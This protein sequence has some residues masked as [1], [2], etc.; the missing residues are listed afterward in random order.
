MEVEHVHLTRPSMSISYVQTALVVH[1][2]WSVCVVHCRRYRRVCALC[3]A[4]ADSD[5]ICDDVDDCVGAYDE[6]NICNGT[7]IPQ[8]E[9]DCNG[10]VLD[11]IG[12]CGGDCTTD[13]DLDNICDDVDPGVGT[14]D[15][16]GVCNGDCTTDADSDGIC[17][18]VDMCRR[19]RR[20]RV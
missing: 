15:A 11:V 3:A 5:G 9:C 10:N 18:D 1:I 8:D 16:I 7:S 4:D 12:V 13:A 6:C 20:Y 17:D 2:H 14:Y 19:V